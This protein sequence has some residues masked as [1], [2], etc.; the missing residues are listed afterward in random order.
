M[1]KERIKLEDI[2]KDSIHSV[3]DGYFDKLP[4]I[5]QNRV[6]EKKNDEVWIPDWRRSVAF[7][8]PV[9]LIM[10]IAYV[11][12]FNQ[13]K[14]MTDPYALLEQVETDDLISYLASTDIS[15]SDLVAGLGEDLDLELVGSELLNDVEFD[16]DQ[17]DTYIDD[18][19]LELDYL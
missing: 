7:A 1:G 11:G 15:T 6:A 10:I 17:I 16:N 9:V 8:I 5:I 19:E 13:E 14:E 12:F 18:Y 3:P 4:G 2:K